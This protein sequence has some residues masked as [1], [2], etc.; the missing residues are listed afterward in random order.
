MRRAHASQSAA[1]KRRCALD[2]TEPPMPD[3]SFALGDHLQASADMLMPRSQR[4]PVTIFDR[5]QLIGRRSVY[6]A[7][8]F[9]IRVLE[10]VPVGKSYMSVPQRVVH[11]HDGFRRSPLGRDTDASP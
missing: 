5:G 9:G 4:D 3:Q 2:L 7:N 6:P 11:L 1:R 10:P 8:P